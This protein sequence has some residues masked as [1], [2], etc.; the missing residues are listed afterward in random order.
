MA[1][2]TELIKGSTVPIILK[3]LDE[4]ERYGYEIVKIVNDRTD[5][6]FQWKEGTL[7]PCLHELEANGLVT[8]VW[9]EAE[10]GKQR[11]YYRITRKGRT[12]LN[13]RMEEWTAFS[14]AVNVLLMGA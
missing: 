6:A 10:S 2:R 4:C 7:Y 1:F 5:G 12:E 11:K 9:R 8:S 14:K 3:L 13:S